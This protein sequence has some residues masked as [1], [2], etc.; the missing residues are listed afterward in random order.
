MPTSLSSLTPILIGLAIA[1]LVI[2]RQFSAR[3]VASVWMIAVPFGLA[4]FGATGL[5]NLDTTGLVLVALNTSLAVALGVMRGTTFRIWS[6][7]SGEALM[8]GT[9]L[10]V[11]LWAATIGVR[12]VVSLIERQLGLG[13]STIGGADL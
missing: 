12:V 13:L 1:A 3:R 2:V 11:L 6:G 9:R 5:G 7:A 10:T 8:Q 4:A